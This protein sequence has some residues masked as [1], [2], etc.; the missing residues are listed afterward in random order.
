[1]KLRKEKFPTE[2]ELVLPVNHHW[3][4]RHYKPNIHPQLVG[5]WCIFRAEFLPLKPSTTLWAFEDVQLLLQQKEEERFSFSHIPNPLH[6]GLFLCKSTLC[7]ALIL[8]QDSYL[9]ILSTPPLIWYL[10]DTFYPL[11]TLTSLPFLS[12]ENSLEQRACTPSTVGHQAEANPIQQS[13]LWLTFF[14]LIATQH[15]FR[16]PQTHTGVPFWIASSFPCSL[17][18]VSL[19]LAHSRMWGNRTYGRCIP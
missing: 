16:Q 15:S 14:L 3:L 9:I 8:L 6:K 19:S 4:S 5:R 2:D 7:K 17:G 1:M 13:L 18:P 10:V 11:S 12:L